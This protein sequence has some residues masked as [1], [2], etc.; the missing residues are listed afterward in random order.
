MDIILTVICVGPAF[1]AGFWLGAV[2]AIERIA[3]QGL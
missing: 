3:R 2:K 1:F